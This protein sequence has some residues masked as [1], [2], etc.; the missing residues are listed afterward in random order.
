MNCTTAFL[1]NLSDSFGLSVELYHGRMLSASYGGRF[2]E[3]KPALTYVAPYF[4]EENRAC[5]VLAHGFVLSGLLS[6]PGT[7]DKIVFGPALTYEVSFAQS[8]Q[9]RQQ[10]RY[11]ANEA[12]NFYRFLSLL[13]RMSITSF[14]G[15]LRLAA[16][17]LYG[18][19]AP[20]VTAETFSFPLPEV[21]PPSLGDWNNLVSEAP[22]RQMELLVRYGRVEEAQKYMDEL[23]RD[24]TLGLPNL[25]S[26]DVMS[27]KYTVIASISTV[28]HFAIAGGLDYQSATALS[29]YYIS[30][31]EFL[32]TYGDLLAIFRSMLLDYTRR[33]SMCLTPQTDSPIVRQACQYIYAHRYEKLTTAGIAEDLHFS[34]S[35]LCHH[36]KEKTG[37]TLTQ[38][39]YEQKV[40]EA[41]YL[42]ES[43]DKSLAQIADMLAYSSQQQFQSVFLQTAGITPYQF[44]LQ[45]GRKI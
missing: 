14:Q 2:S 38:Q 23:M 3:F 33:V 9:I 36:F 13:P 1:Q 10:F 20:E 16:L 43:T 40:Q 21:V 11:P 12:R 17:Y 24:T 25:A 18:E 39:I 32:S 34:K 4:E 31:V 19:E 41:K 42:L 26:N 22:E 45:A 7:D 6:V 8:E 15:M 27:L 35:Y 44:R 30:R 29:D 37:K 5:L 28:A